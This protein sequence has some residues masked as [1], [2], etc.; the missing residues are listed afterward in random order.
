VVFTTEGTERVRVDSSGNTGFGTTSP[1]GRVASQVNF[2]NGSNANYVAQAAGTAQGQTA[3][4]S[5][6]STFVGTGDNTPRRSADIWS[7]FNGGSWGNEYIAFG[8]GNNG[9]SNDAQNQTAEKMRITGGGDLQ[10]NSGYGSV[11]TAYGCRA[12]VNFNGTGTVAIREDGNVSSITDNGTGDY[13]VNFATAMPDGNYSVGAWCISNT[14]NVGSQFGF[15]SGRVEG[16]VVA[17]SVRI[18]S[19]T[20]SNADVRDT[21]LICVQTFR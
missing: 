14:T 18:T 16:D 12:W 9:S 2:G 7:G 6:R 3:G 19:S 5:F 20:S 13:T 21:P 8:V 17:G 4:Y 10:F 11:A 15:I 1:G